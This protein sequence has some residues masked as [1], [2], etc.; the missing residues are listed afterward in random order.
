MYYISSNIHDYNC[1]KILIEPNNNIETK[2][3][4][5]L[6]KYKINRYKYVVMNFRNKEYY[7]N[8]SIKF[9]IK[10]ERFERTFHRNPNLNNYKG[11]KEYLLKR[12]IKL[13]KVN[14]PNE[15][16][17]NGRKIN[18]DDDI[19][20]LLHKYCLF[21]IACN[22]G[23]WHIP[24]I[25]NRPFIVLDDT[26]YDLWLHNSDNKIKNMATFVKIF[27]LRKK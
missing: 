20:I 24:L 9:G 15:I 18:I 25:F 13:I 5:F 27:D 21:S 26:N 22:T 12:K 3:I 14:S 23:S 1:S 7:N 10:K 4:L 2:I 19:S 16:V 11:F 6:K 17:F 8:I